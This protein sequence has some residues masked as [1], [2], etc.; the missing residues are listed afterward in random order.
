MLLRGHLML[1]KEITEVILHVVQLC[2]TRQARH[3]FVDSAEFLDSPFQ[4]LVLAMF[5]SLIMVFSLIGLQ[6]LEF[7]MLY[8]YS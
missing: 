4:S 2:A 6:C 1:L 3:Y 8:P 7:V 5:I